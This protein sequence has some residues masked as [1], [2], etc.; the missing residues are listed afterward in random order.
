MTRDHLIWRPNA[1][2]PDDW[3]A[4]TREEQ[5]AW[6]KAQQKP[7]GLKR[8]M[9]EAIA[10]YDEGNITLGDFI[11][12]VYKLAVPEEIEEFVRVCPPDMLAALKESLAIY[13]DDEK[14]WP[15]TY[16]IA[17]HFPWVTP[18]EIEKSKRQE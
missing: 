7:P 15:R 16:S 4:L 14:A 8:H 18:E 13:G 6:W 9:K 11:S 2:A 1:I 10:L 3:E 12:L 5:I 17:A